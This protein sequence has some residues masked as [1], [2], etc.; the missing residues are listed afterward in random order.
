VKYKL[1]MHINFLKQVKLVTTVLFIDTSFHILRTKFDSLMNLVNVGEM[2]ALWALL[3]AATD[4]Y[5]YF[6]G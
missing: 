3:G 5:I 1:K 6:W 4:F 2:E